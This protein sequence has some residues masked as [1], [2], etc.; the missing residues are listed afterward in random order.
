MC[1]D[2]A[3][4]VWLSI[5]TGLVAT[6]IGLIIAAAV[7]NGSFFGA[8]ASPGLML[9]AAAATGGAVVALGFAASAMQEYYDCLRRVGAIGT[10]CAGALANWMNNVAALKTV[11]GIQAAA[12][13]ANA[14][15]AW[16]PW[17]GQVQMWVILGALIAQAVLIVSL[18]FFI[19]ELNKCLPTP[20]PASPGRLPVRQALVR[21]PLWFPFR[22]T[23]RTHG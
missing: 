15:I 2:T 7:A 9:G 4:K 10:Q 3:V 18:G 16:I 8:W 1:D 5:A 12:C 6:A 13:L 11:L 21:K 23:P 14:A 17:G 22:H 20:P 19:S